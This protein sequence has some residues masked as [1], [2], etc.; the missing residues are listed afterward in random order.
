MFEWRKE[1]QGV[2]KEIKRLVMNIPIL[3]LHDPELQN[4]IRPNTSGF[5]LG[6]VYEQIKENG[7]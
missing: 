3:K 6:L 4:L 1:Q 5:T 7:E 2:F